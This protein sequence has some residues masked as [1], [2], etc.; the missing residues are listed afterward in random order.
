[1]TGS[2]YIIMCGVAT[3]VPNFKQTSGHVENR[4]VLCRYVLFSCPVQ[5]MVNPKTDSINHKS[6]QIKHPAETCKELTG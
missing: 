1:M 5:E 6:Q 4:H 3:M 2:L